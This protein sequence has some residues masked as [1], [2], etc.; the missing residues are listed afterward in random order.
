VG[1][2]H[3]FLE[4][5]DRATREQTE[6]ALSLYRDHE[7]L[8][9]VL[10]QARLPAP[11][12]APRVALAIADGGPHIVVT[13]EGTFVTCLGAGMSTGPHPVVPR[14]KLDALLASVADLRARQKMAGSIVRPGEAAHEILGRLV[15]RGDALTLEEFTAISGWQ[16]FLADSFFRIMCENIVEM[17]EWQTARTEL[18]SPSSLRGRKALIAL[19]NLYWSI[20]HLA[21]LSAMGSRDWMEETIE[22]LVEGNL[23]LSYAIARLGSTALAFK[24]WWFA[25]RLGKPLMPLYKRRLARADN[26]LEVLDGMCALTAIGLRH[27]GLRAEAKKAVLAPLSG[28]DADIV[29]FHNQL[30]ADFEDIFDNPDKTANG[31]LEI[32]RDHFLECTSHLPD[33]SPWRFAT[34]ADVPADLARACALGVDLDIFSN[35]TTE[36]WCVAAL[37]TVARAKAEDFYLPREVSNIVRDP[38]TPERCVGLVMRFREMDKQEPVRSEKKVGRNDRCPCGSGKKFKKCCGASA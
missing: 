18:P 10:D 2:D 13:R 22:K 26:L 30:A 8:K 23:S 9:F 4:R 38:W 35:T 29:S 32:A 37:S 34:A 15:K 14:A 19:G 31:F 25:A 24:G 36:P 28:V 21:L 12:Q 17:S 33:G 16:P 1:H 3:H 11:E 27:T 6:F 5:L 7:A 20:G